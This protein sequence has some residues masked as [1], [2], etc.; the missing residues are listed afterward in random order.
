MKNT[1]ISLLALLALVPAFLAAQDPA[2]LHAIELQK[3]GDFANAAVEYRAFLAAHPDEPAIRSNLGVVLSNLGRYEEAEQEY[4]EAL[5]LT[6]DHPDVQFGIETNLALAYY[7]SGRIPDA[8]KQLEHVLPHAAANPQIVLLLADCYLRMGE[9]KK[10][11]E[12]LQPLRANQPDDLGVA[13]VLGM[14]LLREKRVPEGQVVLDRILKDSD[15]PESHFLLGSQMY[16]A[17]DF[18]GSVREF[19]AAAERNP[20]LPSLQSWYGQ[21]LLNTGD[22]DAAAAAFRKELAHDPADFEANLR[23]AEILIERKKPDEAAPL[24]ERAARVRP[25]SPEIT[26]ARA[27]FAPPPSP[28]TGKPAPAFSLG[29]VS[30]ASYRGKSPVLLVFGSY[31]CPNFRAAAPALNTLYTRYNKRVPFLMVYIREAHSTADW[32]STRNNRDGITDP[33]RRHDGRKTKPRGSLR[34][35]TQHSLSL[36]R[37][38]H[39]RQSGGC[40]PGMAQSRLPR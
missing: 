11:I 22:P 8:A 5:R 10:A 31:S 38:W 27:G 16:S 4:R 6:T 40:V 18:P 17:G 30:L 15:S 3:K 7:K 20:D 19:Q 36:R 2:V 21:A 14:A 13:Y 25:G 29:R 23:L 32:Q 35:Q 1:R 33:A 37:G 28:L 26:R 9:N 12:L 24:L 34:P 39:G